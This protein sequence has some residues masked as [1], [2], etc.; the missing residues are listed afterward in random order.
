MFRKAAHLKVSDVD[1]SLILIHARQGKGSR[2]SEPPLTQKVLDA[3]R[4][5]WRAAKIKARAYSLRASA[6]L[7]YEGQ[8]A[9]LTSAL[10]ISEFVNSKTSQTWS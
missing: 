9:W 8:D 7:P 4:E 2:D 10:A 3:W 5:Y 6:K 1:S